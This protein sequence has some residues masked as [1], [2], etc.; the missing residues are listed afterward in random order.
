MLKPITRINI[1]KYCK[2]LGSI[3]ITDHIVHKTVKV[4]VTLLLVKVMKNINI[5]IRLDCPRTMVVSKSVSAFPCNL[6]IWTGL[7]HGRSNNKN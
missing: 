3:G 4:G 5:N 1:T 6:Y 7:N 2:N